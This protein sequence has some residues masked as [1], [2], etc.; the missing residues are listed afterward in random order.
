MENKEQDILEQYIRQQQE[1]VSADAW[2]KQFGMDE[3]MDDYLEKSGYPTDHA[4]NHGPI[5]SAARQSASEEEILEQYRQQQGGDFTHNWIS[6]FGM[7][8]IVDGYL[9][10]AG[11]PT[12]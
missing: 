11:F 12:D 9:E 4:Q 5:K 3:I 1:T 8:N 6:Q 10:K 7:D 2:I